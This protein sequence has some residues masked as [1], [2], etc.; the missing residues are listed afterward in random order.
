MVEFA[1]AWRSVGVVLKNGRQ[2][3][4]RSVLLATGN[5]MPSIVHSTVKNVSSSWAIATTPQPQNVWKDGALIWEDSEH[6]HCAR[7]TAAGR[8]IIGG[9]DSDEIVEPDARDRL[10]PEKSR[11]LAPKLAA[12]WPTANTGIEF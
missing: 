4:E 8:I 7:T 10:I 1:A 2:I 3:E 9:E 12:P 5:V 6:Y 11:I